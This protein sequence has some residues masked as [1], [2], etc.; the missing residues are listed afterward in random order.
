MADG[1]RV[2]NG[3]GAALSSSTLRPGDVLP[4]FVLVTQILPET[5][6]KTACVLALS[7]GT[8]ANVS[9]AYVVGLLD[10]GAIVKLST[11]ASEL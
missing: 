7:T 8:V 9:A 10:S 5:S 3:R 1:S 2:P 11:D 4:G 6:S